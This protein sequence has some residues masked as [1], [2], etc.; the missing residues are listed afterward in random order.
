MRQPSAWLD[1]VGHSF[2]VGPAEMPKGDANEVIIKNHSIAINPIDWKLRD[3]GWLIQTWP[4]VL[5]CDG[6]GVVVDVGS[7]VHH[8]KKGDRVIGHAVSLMSQNPKN[9]AFQRY[10]AVETA[11]VAKIPDSLSFNEACV[12]PLALDTAGTGLFSDRDQGY[13]ALEWPT[14]LPK[15]SDKKPIIYG[16]SS[17]VGTVGIQLAAATEAYVVAVA[18]PKNFDLCRSCGVHEVFDHNDPLVIDR[19]VQTVK[20]AKPTDFVGILDAVSEEESFK[21]VVA[22]IEKLGSGNLTTVLA[23]PKDIPSHSKTS[24]IEGINNIADPLWADLI[25]PALEEGK[26]KCLPEPYV[27]GRGLESVEKGCLTNK[28]GVSTKKLVIELE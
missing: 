1:G 13:L 18:S 12:S 7:D 22:M 4:M 11:K 8:V 10:V 26:L 28:K 3:L 27:I 17:S 25:A 5:G 9:V 19:V 15:T 6:A 2:R 24:C 16:G 21:I 23:G 20:A 14:L